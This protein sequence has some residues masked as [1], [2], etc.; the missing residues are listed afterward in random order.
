MSDTTQ[1][2]RRVDKA[3]QAMPVISGWASLVLMILAIH[4]WVAS[5]FE[6]GTRAGMILSFGLFVMWIWGYWPQLAAKVKGWAQRG[7]VN[8]SLIAVGLVVALI[9]GNAM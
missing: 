5:G 8:T 2:I 3:D 1:D 7:G 6:W 4:R 9:L